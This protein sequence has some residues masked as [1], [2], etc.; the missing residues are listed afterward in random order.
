MAAWCKSLWSGLFESKRMADLN[1]TGTPIFNGNGLSLSA[2]RNPIQF[3][4]ETD[5]I[6]SPSYAYAF[7]GVTA[8]IV[9]G[10]V[11]EINGRA[12]TASDD[13]S[14]NEFLTTTASTIVQVRQSLVMALRDDPD[15]YQY[16][17]ETTALGIFVRAVQN[18]TAYNLSF[19]LGAGF[20]NLG[21]VNG[22]NQYR[23]QLLEDY[24]VWMELNYNPAFQFAQ[25]LNTIPAAVSGNQIL[26]YY[27]LVFDPSNEHV[28]DV[29]STVDALVDYETPS[30]AIGVHLQAS[31]IKAF[32]VEY[33][34][35]YI[36]AGKVN[37][38]RNIIGR[39]NVFYAVNS[40]LGT[41]SANDLQ[42]YTQREPLQKFLTTQPLSRS[43]RTT[44]TSWLSFIW[45][46]PTVGQRWMALYVIVT[47]YDGSSQVVG[48]TQVTQMEAG[49]NTVRIDP[50]SWGMPT[51][52]TVAGKLV[53]GY[54]VYLQEANNA[55][56]VGAVTFSE[57]RHFEIDR[58]C[59]TSGMVQFAWLETIGGW[60]SFSFFGESISDLERAFTL[61]DRGRK[62]SGFETTDQ[63]STVLNMNTRFVTTATSG[64]LDEVAFRWLRES[65]LKSIAVYVVSGSDLFPV[66]ITAHESK[67]G[68]DDLTFSLA[69]TF[70]LSA[71]SNSLR[72]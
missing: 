31:P 44:D 46:T 45:Y 30:T 51:I 48:N 40:A 8:P 49:Y 19:T 25:Y 43:I 68:T 26:A 12:Y 52:E 55:L 24:R 17:F 16:E 10:T 3:T 66:T 41:L 35:S 32:F 9:A 64:E 63:M 6:G 42:A 4:F 28:F 59:P 67:S 58:L 13:P 23:G 62:R 7:I 65:L 21:T 70:E 2:S 69:V 50:N 61:F 38:L 18:G 56:M 60:T 71:V 27:Y 5:V 20:A 54:D 15:N 34:E 22:T 72:G 36:P 14:W 53:R 29:S 37:A 39:S 47:F 11:F 33:G 1:L 57:L